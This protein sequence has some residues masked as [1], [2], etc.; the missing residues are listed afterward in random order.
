M[1]IDREQDR[2]VEVRVTISTYGK[3]SQIT[4][5]VAN[6]QRILELQ[7]GGK[8]KVARVPESPT[9]DSQPSQS[10]AMGSPGSVNGQTQGHGQDVRSVPQDS[11]AQGVPRSAEGGYQLPVSEPEADNGTGRA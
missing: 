3:E 11:A 6:V 7:F 10:G 5:I 4:K 1:A 8:V 9:L 2:D